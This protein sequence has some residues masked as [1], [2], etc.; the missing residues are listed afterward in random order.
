M[1]PTPAEARR[2]AAR[3]DWAALAAE[4]DE[5]GSAATGPLLT[6][7]ECADLAALYDEP[8]LFRTT[9]DLGRH[10][11]WRPPA[12]DAP[13]AGPRERSGACRPRAAAVAAARTD[14][15]VTV[16]GGSPSSGPRSTHT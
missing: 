11:V 1:T 6:P 12:A 16:M 4:L 14:L 7:A 2:R 5:Q 13:A 3:T 10:P 15:R 8:G 9:V